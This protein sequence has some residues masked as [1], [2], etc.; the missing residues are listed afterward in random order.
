M[1][2]R[3]ELSFKNKVVRMWLIIMI[4]ALIVEILIVKFTKVPVFT[5]IP[6]A[7]FFV[8][9]YFHKRKLKKEQSAT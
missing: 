5:L 4:P 8:W 1:S 3:F 6:W 9:Y 2:D 7:I